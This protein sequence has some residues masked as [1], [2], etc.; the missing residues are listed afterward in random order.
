[1][2]SEKLIKNFLKHHY[3]IPLALGLLIIYFLFNALLSYPIN[4]SDSQTFIVNPNDGFIEISN[5]L[6][7]EKL[8]INPILFDIYVL[9]NGTY[10]KLKAGEYTFT[11]T[12]N[13]KE[14]AEHLYKGQNDFIVIP[15]GF[16]IFQID[17][18][19]HQ[20]HILDN[21][22]SILQYTI[23]DFQNNNFKFLQELDPQK[24]LE[25]FLFPDSYVF[26]QNTPS[27]TIIN[28]MLEN[29]NTKV[30]KKYFLQTNPKDF[31]SNLILA[32]ILEKEIL[33]DQEKQLGADILLRRLQNNIRLQTDAVLCYI[34]FLNNKDKTS[35]TLCQNNILYLKSIN[36]AYNIYKYNGLP[37]TPICNPGISSI[38]AILHP[39]QNNFYY[40]ITDPI[41]K[42]TIFAKT[43]KEHN[44]NIQKYLK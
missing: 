42:K 39:I 37:P 36:S 32:S 6:Y 31:Y 19:L 15:E 38:F 34:E 23:G 7:K 30:Y 35:E 24:S 14:I 12:I 44:Q 25:G 20:E 10:N 18:K 22:D 27:K 4:L 3:I 43:L 41:T 21:N 9:F 17:A 11:S 8:I 13:I 33:D 2:V 28:I 29:F 26:I 16:N 1:M 5:N 40:Y